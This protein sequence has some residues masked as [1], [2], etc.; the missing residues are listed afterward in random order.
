MN[1]SELRTKG[2]NWHNGL[3]EKAMQLANA[4]F[5]DRVIIKSGR[6]QG[7]QVKIIYVANAH[8]VSVAAKVIQVMR[9]NLPD[10]FPEFLSC[11]VGRQGTAYDLDKAYAGEADCSIEMGPVAEAVVEEVEESAL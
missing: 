9:E 6:R 7:R 3:E 11:E 8:Q 2:E 5:E 1:W 4:I 10:A